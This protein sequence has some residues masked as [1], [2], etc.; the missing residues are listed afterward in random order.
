MAR[1]KLLILFPDEWLAYSPTVINLF[2]RL[3]EEHD[4]AVVAIDTGKYLRLNEAGVEYVQINLQL[5][6]AL[7]ALGV[8]RLWKALLLR[9]RIARYAP[10]AIVAVDSAAAWAAQSRGYRIHY[11]SLEAKRDGFLRRL[12]PDGI[13]SVIVQTAE[14]Y[15]FLFG[16]AQLSTHLVQNA[17]VFRGPQRRA[18]NTNALVFLGN[19]IPKHGIFQCVEFLRLSARWTLTV[20]GN[21]PGN[22]RERLEAEHAQLIESGRLLL[23]DAYLAEDEVPEFLASFYAGFCFYDRELIDPDDFNYLTSPS[24]KLFNYYAAGVPVVASDMPGLSSVGERQTGVAVASLAADTIAA[25]VATI[26]LRHGELVENCLRAAEHFS[27]DKAIEPFVRA[28]TPLET[29]P[30]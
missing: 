7:E 15:R 26:E 8:Y 12:R 17:P 30:Q 4:V 25:A 29:R 21:I 2:H 28:L 10:D 22:V 27:F 19:A 24:G 14:R 9:G 6:R 13:A 18:R 5:A 20:K 23:D 11:L 16:D 3:R 1:L